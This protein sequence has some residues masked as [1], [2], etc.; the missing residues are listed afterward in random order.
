MCFHRILLPARQ[1]GD[2]GGDD[3]DVEQHLRIEGQ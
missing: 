2:D 1:C 3:D